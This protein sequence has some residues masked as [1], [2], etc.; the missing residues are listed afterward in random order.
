IFSDSGNTVSLFNSL[1]A[2][3]SILNHLLKSS[4]DIL[5]KESFQ[6]CVLHIPGNQNHIADALSRQN[7]QCA[8]LF[9]PDISFQKFT[10]PQDAL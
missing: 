4:I 7:F 9:D 6:L 10:P 1:R 3:N 8:L 2:S 5:L